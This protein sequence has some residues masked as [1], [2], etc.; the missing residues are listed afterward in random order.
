VGVIYIGDRYAGKTHL[1]LELANPVHECVKV[2]SPNY[3]NLK[4]LLC[5]PA[6]G[7]TNPTSVMQPRQIDI[8]VRLPAGAG[9]VLIDW[10]D[11]PGEMWRLK[12]Q[13]DNPLLWQ[14]FLGVIKQS[15]GIMLV[16]SPYG[17][18]IGA[19]GNPDDFPTFQQWHKRF[20]R[21]VEFFRAYCPNLRHLL[22]CLN[23]ADLFC[24]IKQES[25]KLAYNTDSYM[26]NWHQR[27]N[28]V[29]DH[30]FRPVK[31]QLEQL[32][33]SIGGLSVRCFITTIYDRSLLEIPWIYLGS[34]LSN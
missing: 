24:D 8:Q 28:Y 33:R 7:S 10:I 4:T 18:M 19:N 21:W 15:E 11:T 13:Q 25:A 6:T 34:F 9:K 26:M 23:K 12:W 20:E 5:D 16:L 27:H 3:D 14:Q 30:Y 32:N 22:I 1:A 17:E 2:L 29:L 31:P